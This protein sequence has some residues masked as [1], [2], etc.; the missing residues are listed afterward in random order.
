MLLITGGCGFIGLNLVQRL[1]SRGQ[2]GIRLLDNLSV[3]SID[4]LRRLLETIGPVQERV[5]GTTRC[6]AVQGV[7]L[8]LQ[9][10]DIGDRVV[11]LTAASGVSAVVHLAAHT[12]VVPSV[13]DPF[14]DAASNVLGVLNMLWAIREQGGPSFIFA[15]SGAPLGRQDP[16]MREDQVPRPLSPYGA[17]K[18]AGEGYCSAFAGSYGLSTTV[19]RF[20]NVYGPYSGHKESVIA[21]FLRD[22]AFL[23]RLTIYGDGTQTRDFIHVD[24]IC[25]AIEA[26]LHRAAHAGCET[27]QI[28]TGIETRIIDL[29]EL[30][31]AV[32]G[33]SVEVVFEPPRPGEV[34]RNFADIAHA[35]SVLGFVPRVDLKTGVT[36]TWKW[37]DTARAG[38][39]AKL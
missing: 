35:R 28:G 30:I 26:V 16:P 17:S 14:H 7:E 11:C 19:L 18:L 29:A 37:L 34:Q 5:A 8:E 23:R 6:F 36:R 9:I 39:V 31:R 15:S 10:G 38:A 3:G 25:G 33:G 4:D 1:L 12:G 24:D 22:A 13:A 20:S 27:Y 2:A 32:S 21:K